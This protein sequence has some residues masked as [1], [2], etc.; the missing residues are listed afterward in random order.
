MDITSSTCKDCFSN[1]AAIPD[2]QS[3]KCNCQTGTFTEK[4]I[5]PMAFSKAMK[6]DL[7]ALQL[8]PDVQQQAF[9][10]LVNILSNS[11]M[12]GVKSINSTKLVMNVSNV[13]S[14]AAGFASRMQMNSDKEMHAL[15]QCVPITTRL[16]ASGADVQQVL[17]QHP[18]K[19][20]KRHIQ[21]GL[22]VIDL[23]TEE[24]DSDGDDDCKMPANK[25]SPKR[26]PTIPKPAARVYSP[27]QDIKTRVVG[28][29]LNTLN[30]GSPASQQA[31]V[32]VIEELSSNAGKI[33]KKII[34]SKVD[35]GETS[36]GMWQEI[37]SRL[38]KAWKIRNSNNCA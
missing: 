15:Q 35:Q 2:C 4:E 1:G 3:C 20:G 25:D 13:M 10:N 27:G 24:E 12:D 14:A 34:K 26:K 9:N 6:D 28:Q 33:L 32:D 8:A 29:L 17:S 19:K 22:S 7:Q 16:H 38:I 11:I 21:N 36:F 18:W 31:A 30:K 37:S 5:Q 23:A